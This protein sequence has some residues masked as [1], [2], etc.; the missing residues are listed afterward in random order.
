MTAQHAAS[1]AARASVAGHV[2]STAHVT[3]PGAL[4]VQTWDPNTSNTKTGRR[5][6]CCSPGSPSSGPSSTS[7]V[8]PRAPT[9]TTGA[10][11]YPVDITTPRRHEATDRRTVSARRSAGKPLTATQSDD[12]LGRN[13]GISV[14]YTVEES[15]GTHSV[16]RTRRRHRPPVVRKL[17]AGA[18][19][20]SALQLRAHGTHHRRERQSGPGRDRDDADERPPVLDAVAADRGE[21]ELRVVPRRGRPGGRRSG[22]DA[23]R[24]RGRQHAPTPSPLTDQINFAKLQSATLERS[25]SGIAEHD[26][27]RRRS[28]NPQAI[29]GA[30]YQGLLVGVVGGKGGVIKPVT[31]T[32]PDGSGNFRLVLPSSARGLAGQ[33]LGGATAVLLDEDGQAGR[34]R[35]PDDLSRSRSRRTR[36]RVSR[37]SSSRAERTSAAGADAAASAVYDGQSRR[38]DYGTASGVTRRS[39]ENAAMDETEAGDGDTGAAGAAAR[40]LLENIETVVHGKQEE[41]RLV[42]AALVSGGHVLFEDVPG[43][44][45]TVLAR[46]IAGS[47]EGAVPSRIQCTPDLQPTD[48]TGLSVFNQETRKFEFQPGPLFANVLLVDEINR[49]MP[50][51]QSA[52]LE[53]M[54]ERQVT[55]DGITPRLPDPFFLHRDREPD[56]VRGHVP[57]AGGPARPLR[58]PLEP[59][60]SRR[61]GGAADRPRAAARASARRPRAR[62]LARRDHRAPPGVARTSTSTS[63]STRWIVQ[64]VRA[65]R[66]LDEVE[67]GAS[68]RGSLALVKVARAWALL[69]GRLFVKPDDVDALFV[70]VLGHRLMLSPD[71]PRRDAQPDARRD[72]PAHPRALPR[73]RPRAAPGLASRRRRRQLDLGRRGEAA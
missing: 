52:L 12:L 25:A 23:G 34:R 13:T 71:L 36:P 5:A 69:H 51:T 1:S 62:D 68:V 73:A 45:K 22:A 55:V 35:R 8:G 50:K 17:A 60:L 29:A 21:R 33:F 18:S 11:E 58:A 64:L 24:G 26:A 20:R 3:A 30:I 46:A 59:R 2:G 72:A 57:A 56:R 48:V 7:T 43:T 41:I 10:F 42:L 63:C 31:A 38:R 47:I 4:F 15:L 9:D 54:A 14:G 44:A 53:A 16:R 70:P 6:T 28:L 67:V 19:D 27:R 61:G 40:R 39:W 49:A 66:T 37:L 65:T 32:W